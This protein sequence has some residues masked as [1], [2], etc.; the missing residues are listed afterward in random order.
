MSTREHARPHLGDG[1]ERQDAHHRLRFGSTGGLDPDERDAEE[2]MQRI[3]DEVDV[4]DACVR[5]VAFGPGEKAVADD[6]L[7]RREAVA[8]DEVLDE[9]SEGGRDDEHG[10]P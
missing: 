8:K 10:C 6:D 5:N 9:G 3:L 2:A 4:L 7:V 1:I